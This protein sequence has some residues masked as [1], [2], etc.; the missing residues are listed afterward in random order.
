MALSAKW[1]CV[2][3]GCGKTWERSATLDEHNYDGTWKHEKIGSIEHWSSDDTAWGPGLPDD[4]DDWIQIPYDKKTKRHYLFFH[5][6]ACDIGWLSV[7]GREKEI[8]RFN[9]AVWMA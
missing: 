2:C 5:E 4:S 7:Q 8:E 3:D 6:D 9:K 1:T